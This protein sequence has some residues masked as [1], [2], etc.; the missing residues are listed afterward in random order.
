MLHAGRSV[1]QPAVCRW[2]WWDL[3]AAVY[4]SAVALAAPGWMCEQFMNCRLG[5]VMRHRPGARVG[6][7]ARNW[8]ML[9]C[10]IVVLLGAPVGLERSDGCH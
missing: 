5:C 6:C 10:V 3:H 9:L 4:M 7:I 8:P 1:W 2:R